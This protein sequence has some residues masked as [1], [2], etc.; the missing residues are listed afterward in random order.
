MTAGRTQRLRARTGARALLT[1]GSPAPCHGVAGA[2]SLVP[3]GKAWQAMTSG[4]GL[5]SPLT[6]SCITRE[7]GLLISTARGPGLTAWAVGTLDWVARAPRRAKTVTGAPSALAAKNGG[8]V[9]K[10]EGNCTGGQR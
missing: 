2:K 6:L 5:A 3:R 4:I 1:G 8:W 7:M 10:R 9:R